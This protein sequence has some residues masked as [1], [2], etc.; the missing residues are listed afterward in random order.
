MKRYKLEV[1]AV[2]PA[3][4]DPIEFIEDIVLD[5][6]SA[7]RLGEHTSADATGAYITVA[8]VEEVVE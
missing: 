7:G 6:I 3:G 2:L 1:H 5:A 4:V 8:K